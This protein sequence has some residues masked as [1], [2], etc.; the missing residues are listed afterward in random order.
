MR[1][2][3][4]RFTLLTALATGLLALATFVP[5]RAQS[6]DLRDD[7]SSYA[8]GT[9]PGDPWFADGFLWE[10][11]DGRVRAMC[12]SGSQLTLRRPQ[13]FRRL[14][15][16]VTL[17]VHS[18]VGREWKVAGIGFAHDSERRWHAAL[19]ESPDEAGREHWFEVAMGLPGAWPTMQGVRIITDRNTRFNWEYDHPYRIILDLGDG[20]LSGVLQELD[21]TVLAEKVCELS[22]P[23]VM[24]GAPS[25]R[26]SSFEA[27]FDDVVMQGADYA[28]T[29]EEE[30]TVIPPLET[31]I[32]PQITGRKTG[33]FHV[34]QIDG[35]WWIIEPGGKGYYAIGTDHCR[36]GGHWCQALGYAPYGRN[37]KR[38]YGS[39]EAWAETA[40]NRLKRWNFNLVAAGHSP[41][42]RY[43]GLPHTEFI[44]FGSGYSGHDALVEKTTWTGFPNVFSATWEQWCDK[45]AWKMCRPNADNPWLLGYFLDNELEWYGKGGGV[46]GVAIETAKLPADNSGKQALVNLLKQ[47]HGD[48]I[49]KLNKAWGAE[50]ESWEALASATT[51]EAV[52]QEALRE[53]QL[54]FVAEVADRYFRTTCEAIRRWDPNHMILGSRFAGDAPPGV[55]EAAGR[56]CDIV[57]FN[58]YGRVDLLRT[59]AP[60]TA[61]RWTEYYNKAKRPLMITEWSFPALDSGLPCKHGA[62][63]RVDTQTQKAL[64]YEVYQRMIFSLPFMVGSDYFMWVDEPAL[65]ISDTFPEDSN[66]GLVNEQ[67]EPYEELTRTATR[68]NTLAYALHSGKVPKVV[69]RQVALR[70][71]RVQAEVANTG[72]APAA[73]DLVFTIDGRPQAPQRMQLAPGATRW[74]ALEVPLTPPAYVT[75]TADPSRKLSD[76]NRA[77]NTASFL[78]YRASKWPRCPAGKWITRWP[79]VLTAGDVD[80]P[81]GMVVTLSGQ[82]LGLKGLAEQIGRRLAA[83]DASGEVVPCQLEPWPEGWQVALSVPAGP[84]RSGLVVYLYLADTDLPQAP[85]SVALTVE[86]NRWRAENGILLLE[87]TEGGNIVDSITYKGTPMGRLNPLVWERRGGQDLWTQTVKT[88]RVEAFT[89]PVRTALQ[90]W[91]ESAPEQPSITAV[92]N[93]GRRARQRSV[94]HHFRVAHRLGMAPDQAWFT[95]EF[96]SLEN[97]DKDEMELRG[98]FQYLLSAIGG[99]AEDDVEG[100]PQVPNYW[101]N[102]GAW[103]D[104][105]TGLVLGAVPVPDERLH[106]NFWK[107]PGGS[108]HADLRRAF[109]PS[110]LVAAAKTWREEPEV[111]PAFMFAGEA[112]HRP[113][114]DVYARAVALGHTHVRVLNAERP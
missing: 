79:V 33:F 11:R 92:D 52:N 102:L 71:G 1:S 45:L 105:P 100:G 91:C 72:H 37:T 16:E 88:T 74:V 111:P 73:F 51:F 54:A 62:G 13:W 14:H 50:Y 96:V 84:A 49:E 44:S 68:V 4:P 114:S 66:Y 56:Y 109:D 23:A 12:P 75:A 93:E 63:M 18:A 53:D 10:V 20:K 82:S 40:T 27:Y 60:G 38:I 46:V 39:E 99:D 85:P 43:R 97:L 5:C 86:G 58:Y 64:C 65:G 7:F 106:A 9:E 81:N 80:R 59:E 83:F 101:M 35:I 61:E 32:L 67:D 48:S 22:P 90:V 28:G 103:R 41:S 113:W 30:K 21:G 108:Q 55:W 31:Q 98:W 112:E 69:V 6:L 29:P 89:G 110:V 36:Y 87:G 3:M 26:C 107:D 76:S 24:D 8:E 77:D 19:I 42:C 47:R 95:D 25:L 70:D 78:Y 17:T 104:E 15:L 34:E 2:P 57:T 94:P